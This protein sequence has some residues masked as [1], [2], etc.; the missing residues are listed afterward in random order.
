MSKEKIRVVRVPPN[1]PPI[2]DEIS[3]IDNICYFPI[4]NT[5]IEIA[6]DSLDLKFIDF[7]NNTVG[8]YLNNT[9]EDTIHTEGKDIYIYSTGMGVDLLERNRD[10]Q[11]HK[12]YGDII[13]L[14]VHKKLQDNEI[15]EDYTSLTIEQIDQYIEMFRIEDKPSKGAVKKYER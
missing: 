12:I 15:I 11:N 2:L 3:K 9:K 6:R 4:A 8:I 10:I 1:I 5:N 7:D 13:I 14:R